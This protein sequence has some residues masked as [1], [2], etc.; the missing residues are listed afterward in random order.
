MKQ[1][2]LNLWLKNETLSMIEHKLWCRKW[3]YLF[4]KCNLPH[5]SDAYILVRG[6]NTVITGSAA[7]L[8]F[9]NC[10]PFT[11]NIPK[12]DET[13]IHDAEDL[14]LVMSMYNLIEYSSN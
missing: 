6:D 11:K 7:Q 14:D 2:I 4:L 1:V 3:N 5:Y 13:T 9:K 12:I 10:P 8:A